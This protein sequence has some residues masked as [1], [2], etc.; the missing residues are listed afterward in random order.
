MT[1]MKT[2]APRIELHS[3]I[4]NWRVQFVWRA[5]ATC[6][7]LLVGSVYPLLFTHT[8]THTDTR[9]APPAGAAPPTR[10]RSTGPLLWRLSWAWRW[11]MLGWFQMRFKFLS[12][13]PRPFRRCHSCSACFPLRC[14]LSLSLVACFSS[15]LSS[16][17]VGFVL[18]CLSPAFHPHFVFEWLD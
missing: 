12:C 11:L 5:R 1:R 15:L 13:V 10:G 18:F 14:V 16:L 2:N 6:S 9:C 7:C 8:H 4:Y 3:A 17:F